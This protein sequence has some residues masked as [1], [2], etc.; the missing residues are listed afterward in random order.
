MLLI[1]FFIMYE[2]QMIEISI[3][4]DDFPNPI[5]LVVDKRYSNLKYLLKARDCAVKIMDQFLSNIKPIE[6]MDDTNEQKTW[7]AVGNFFRLNNRPYE[8]L[9]LYSSLYEH[10]LKGQIETGRR[11]H[12]GMPL[13]WQ[14][15]CF[16]MLGF[17]SISKKY[18]ML[19]LIEDAIETKGNISASSTGSY[20]RMVWLRGLSESEF[21]RYSKESFDFYKDDPKNG[22]F[23]EWILNKLDHNWMT[24][25]PSN[26]EGNK[27][28]LSKNYLEYL[29][30]LFGDSQGVYL[31]TA[32]QY[33]LSCMPGARTYLRERTNSTDLDIVCNVEG[34]PN[35]FRSELGRYFVCECKDYSRS[36]DPV[37]FSVIAKF[38]R[39]LDSTKTKFGLLFSTTKISG[40]NRRQFAELEII[41]AFQDRGIVIVDFDINDLK[42]VASGGNFINLLRS[43]YESVRLDLKN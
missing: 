36:G 17:P 27:Y 3:E 8:A 12:K 16:N 26:L 2:N 5:P 20:F 19:T 30:T 37:N 41:K 35:D 32:V 25:Y 22:R 9:E 33:I 39:V 43:K 24:E 15:D 10:M 13:C 38:I 23:P 11:A 40:K 18:L 21:H 6:V 31:E 4:G 34:L 1:G 29:I 14:Y 7:E 28:Y 42:Y